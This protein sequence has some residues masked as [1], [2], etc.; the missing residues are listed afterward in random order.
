MEEDQ[1]KSINSYYHKVEVAIQASLQQKLAND[2]AADISLGKDFSLDVN[3]TSSVLI[4]AE[5]NLKTKHQ[6]I[7]NLGTLT[8]LAE[9][10][11]SALK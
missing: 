10:K 1:K 9:N 4:S 11:T 3:V 5:L 6:G 7:K 2:K 8:R